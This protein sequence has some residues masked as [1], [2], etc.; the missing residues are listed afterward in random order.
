MSKDQARIDLPGDAI[1]VTTYSD[2]HRY[3]I[4]FAEGHLD[5]VLLLGRHGT[6]NVWHVGDT[7]SPGGTR[8][9]TKRRPKG[10]SAADG[11]TAALASS[12]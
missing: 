11:R 8:P 5:L 2:L 6:G 1:I 10:G 3:L 4:T 12:H 9:Q 7:G